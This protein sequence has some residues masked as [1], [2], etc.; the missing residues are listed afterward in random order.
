[1]K[2]KY[3]F[4]TNSSSTSF[5]MTTQVEGKIKIKPD[6]DLKT[7][8]E[9]HFEAFKLTRYSDKTYASGYFEGNG[10]EQEPNPYESPF[11]QIY[12]STGDIVDGECYSDLNLNARY[13]SDS[14]DTDEPLTVLFV[15]IIA[16]E[17]RTS[18]DLEFN[19]DRIADMIK[20]IARKTSAPGIKNQLFFYSV[21]G[22]MDSGGWNGGD[23]MG[24]FCNSDECVVEM[25]QMGKILVSSTGELEMTT[26]SLKEII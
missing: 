19:I 16:K 26:I 6:I 5:V 21:P 17:I 1:M 3:S 4:V 10:L 8:M 18:P 24:S 22:E 11:C 2:V 7:M 9:E 13:F 14:D 25:S 20:I 23:P 15:T 12:L